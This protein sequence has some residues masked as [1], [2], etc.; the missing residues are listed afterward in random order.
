MNDEPIKCP[1]CGSS[2][3]HVDKRGFKAGRAIA[4][5]L[6]TGNILAAAA[7]GGIGMNKI[8]LTCIKCGHKF[9]INNT[10]LNE[11]SIESDRKIAE[12]EKRVISKEDAEKYAM[13][14]CDCGKVSSMLVRNPI[15]PKCGR[16]QSENNFYIQEKRSGC[17]SLFVIP[18]VLI[19]LFVYYGS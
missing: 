14:K 8:E 18:L 17:L 9:N 5:G 19:S 13:Y 10:A 15:C 12:F 4:G 3:I 6:L 11:A 16:R 2:Q 1:K 7:C